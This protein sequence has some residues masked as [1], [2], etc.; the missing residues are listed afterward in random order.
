MK[1]IVGLPGNQGTLLTYLCTCPFISDYWSATSWIRI[2][3]HYNINIVKAAVTRDASSY[4]FKIS[5]IVFRTFTA[6]SFGRRL[7]T[8]QHVL[9]AP[10]MTSDSSR[11]TSAVII[12][13]LLPLSRRLFVLA[14][15]VVV[16]LSSA[17]H[18][19]MLSGFLMKL[20]GRLRLEEKKMKING[21]KSRYT[22]DQNTTS[23]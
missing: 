15:L 9:K 13:Y 19:K 7:G 23:V 3:R 14:C 5:R 10:G 1:G 16:R 4:V 8:V 20:G 17:L 21:L 22:A 11:L 6:Q 12:F 2:D 18:K